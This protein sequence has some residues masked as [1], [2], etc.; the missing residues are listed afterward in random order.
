MLRTAWAAVLVA[1]A[2]FASTA[3]VGAE[4]VAKPSWT[5]GDLWTYATNTTIVPGLNLTGSATSTVTGVQPTLVE[6]SPTPVQAFRVVL[7]G[8][9]T[10][11]GSVV[12]S[13]HTV[14]IAGS[15]I[16]T[17]E[18][19]FEAAGLH[20]VYSLLDLSV[21]GTYGGLFPYSIRLQNTTRF[22][23]LVDAWHYPL[24]VNGSGSLRLAY[25]FTRDLYWIDGVRYHDN[26]TGEWNVSFSMGSARP[27]GTPA[28]EFQAYPI[29]ERWSDGSLDRFFF[30]PSVGNNVRTESRDSGGNLTS[31]TVLTAYRYQVLEPARFLGLTLLE[32]G[33]T[34]IAIAA[35]A[36]VSAFL[37]LRSRRRRTRTP[38]DEDSPPE[39]TSGPR[40]P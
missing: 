8:S 11:G 5:A 9:G 18:E 37:F 6:G 35:V 23:I 20:P 12:V 33:M 25:N 34:L 2:L 1:C 39:A 21:N 36:A 31:V 24:S 7:S 26:G 17:G 38:G 15:W 28:G 29:Q 27:V 10:A 13:N 14:T 4:S 3:A 19:R 40:G 16:V 30:A 22:A 32:W